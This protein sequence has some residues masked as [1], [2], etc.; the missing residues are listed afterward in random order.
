VGGSSTGKTRACWEAV[1]SMPDRWWLWH[2]IDPTRPDATARA[3]GDVHPYTVVWL[4]EA[5]HYL[6]TADHALSERVAAGL[7]TLLND[8]SRGPILVLAT[9]WPQYWAAL[10]V[11]PG[12]GGRD[13]YTQARQ[14]LVGTDIAIPDAFTDQEVKALRAAASSDPRLRH[15]VDHA[16]TGGSPSTWPVRRSCCGV[17][18][19]PH[20]P[21]GRS[22]MQLSTRAGLAAGSPCPA[23][24]C[25]GLRLA[26][27]TAMYGIRP[28]TVMPG[29]TTRWP[30]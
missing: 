24:S 9:I 13:P 28:A 19:T 21:R 29:S 25:T 15:A 20:R 18:A 4:N 5:Q 1:R 2:P 14:L 8:A 30:T 3:L 12:G 23:T 7:R 22:S 10:T 17:T 6:L 16:A 27:F 11:P 26:T